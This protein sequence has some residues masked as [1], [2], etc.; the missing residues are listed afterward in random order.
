[1][2]PAAIKNQLSSGGVIFRSDNKTPEIA[3]ISVKGGS[4]WCLPKGIVDKGENPEQTAVREVREETGLNGRIKA[5][6]G[7]VSYWYY[8]KEENA[9][10][11]KT[12]HYYLMEYLSGSTKDHDSEVNDAS[13]FP[14]DEALDKASYK[15]DKEIIG[16]AK[17]LIEKMD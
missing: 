13:W 6:L 1:M 5:K 11:R 7:E 9:R 8:I 2:R 15:G 3:L 14:I 17:K 12:V 16:K 4:V 10:C